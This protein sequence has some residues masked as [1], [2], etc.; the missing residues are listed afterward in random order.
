MRE[1]GEVQEE[2]SSN[3]ARKLK[4][5]SNFQE[6][7]ERN[8]V[9]NRDT[10]KEKES[11]L[12]NCHSLKLVSELCYRNLKVNCFLAIFISLYNETGKTHRAPTTSANN[13]LHTDHDAL[14]RH[15]S[16][17]VPSYLL[18]QYP[19]FTAAIPPSPKK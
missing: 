10:N 12:H 14:A 6:R 3:V 18:T 5:E 7:K 1:G 13:R 9:Q 19:R 11:K 17:V 15:T 4:T 8:K 16:T 2:K